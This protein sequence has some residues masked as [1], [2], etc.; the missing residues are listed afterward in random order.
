MRALH[1]K[2]EAP[3]GWRATQGGIPETGTE[4]IYFAGR[5]LQGLFSRIVWTME[6]R[7]SALDIEIERGS[8]K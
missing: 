7:L 6:Q 2:K 5:W 3:G 8:Q 1:S 4:P